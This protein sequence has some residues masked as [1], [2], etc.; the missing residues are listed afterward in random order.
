MAQFAED[1]RY[2]CFEYIEVLCNRTRQHSLL[3]YR[4]PVQY[5]SDWMNKQNQENLGH[6][7]HLMVN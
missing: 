7:V 4:S 6:E 3:V 5:L 1:A 2:V